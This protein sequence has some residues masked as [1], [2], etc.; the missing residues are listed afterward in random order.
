M[1]RLQNAVSSGSLLARQDLAN[2]YSAEFQEARGPFRAAGAYNDNL[3][4]TKRSIDLCSPST[5]ALDSKKFL[6]LC[7]QK[8]NVDAS[9][10]QG[11]NTFLHYAAPFG[12]C[13]I[14]TTWSSEGAPV[15]ICRASR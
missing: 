8:T 4:F 9:I 1:N 3:Q 11:E 10:D 6:K 7:K 5:L 12:K 2:K 15:S 13:D 14:K